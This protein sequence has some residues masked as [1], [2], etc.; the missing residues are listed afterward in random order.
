MK[1]I[2]IALLFICCSSNTWSQTGSATGTISKVYTHLDNWTVLDYSQRKITHVEMSG[3]PP[4]CGTVH[5]RAV[6]ESTNPIYEETV[7]TAQAAVLTGASVRIDYGASCSV[8]GG[9][10]DLLIL[11]LQ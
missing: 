7:R 8:R 11:V 9:A 2:F 1:S 5:R 10:H 6:I 4:A 3:L